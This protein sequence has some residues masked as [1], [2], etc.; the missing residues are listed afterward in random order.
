M[1]PADSPADISLNFNDQPPAPLEQ[2][3]AFTLPSVPLVQPPASSRSLPANVTALKLVPIQG[4]KKFML[5]RKQSTVSSSTA[6]PRKSLM[7][8]SFT[9]HPSPQPQT[10]PNKVTFS[11]VNQKTCPTTMQHQSVLSSIDNTTLQRLLSHLN[12]RNTSQSPA[13]N[14]A[15]TSLSNKI[16]Y[17]DN[18]DLENEF[19]TVLPQCS[20]LK[21]NTND[22]NGCTRAEQTELVSNINNDSHVNSGGET[23]VEYIDTYSMFSDSTSL[24]EYLATLLPS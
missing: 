13:V 19:F 12:S 4:E 10:L 3:S 18:L 6:A 8:V 14:P 15:K 20:G 21:S 1:T 22:R 5:P 7:A 11:V 9:V 24:N 2:P 17:C 23:L 16:N